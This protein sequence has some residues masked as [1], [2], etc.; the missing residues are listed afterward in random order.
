MVSIGGERMF[1]VTVGQCICCGICRQECLHRAIDYGP[2]GFI[3]HKERCIGCG[4]CAEVC[5]QGCIKYVAI[6]D[7]EA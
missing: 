1:K 7:R 4:E 6:Y 3:I 2:D 5:P